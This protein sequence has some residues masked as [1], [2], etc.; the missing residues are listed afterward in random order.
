MLAGESLGLGTCILGFPPPILKFNKKLQQEYGLPKRFQSGMA[1]VFG[2]PLLRH[3]R[4]IK[5]RFA[6]VRFF[7]QPTT[8][9]DTGPA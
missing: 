4:A 8:P 5:R 1:V 6:D 3:Q 7:G 2:Y 9:V